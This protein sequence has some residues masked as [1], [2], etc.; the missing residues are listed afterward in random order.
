MESKLTDLPDLT[1]SGDY[2]L[3]SFLLTLN[4]DLDDDDLEKLK[5]LCTG[6]Y[7]I[8]E[9]ILENVKKP[10]HL[11]EILRKRQLLNTCNLITLQAMLWVLPRKDL[12]L[13]YVKFADSQKSS[14]HFIVPKDSPE[15]GY[16]FLKFHIKGADLNKYGTGDMEKLRSKISKLLF[17]PPE[18]V[19]IAGIQPSQSLLI[20]VMLLKDDAQRMLTLPP[21]SIAVLTEVHVDKVMIGNKTLLLSGEA[22][23]VTVPNPAS[24]RME[25]ELENVLLRHKQ[26]E[27]E[28][29]NAYIT[30]FKLQSLLASNSWLL[31]YI[32]V[33]LLQDCR[34]IYSKIC[35]QKKLLEN[36]FFN[37]VDELHKTSVFAAFR[38]RLQKA[39]EHGYNEVI[40]YDL[41][42][43]QALVFQW[44]RNERICV[45][46]E[47]LKIEL[48]Y[49]AWE[50]EKLA[51]YHQVGVQD[52]IMSQR[53]EFFISAM[54]QNLPI[55]VLQNVEIHTQLSDE[56]VEYVFHR[57]SQDVSE[58]ELATLKKI[59]K[60]QGKINSPAAASAYE[61]LMNSW[62]EQNGVELHVF[63]QEVLV[64]PLKRLDFLK[65]LDKYVIEFHDSKTKPDHAS[66]S[67]DE[68]KSGSPSSKESRQY[69]MQE[70]II[71]RLSNIE[72]C[73]KR[74]ELNPQNRLHMGSFLD[75]V[76]LNP[77]GVINPAFPYSKRLVE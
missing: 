24:S 68:M 35:A 41:L 54:I 63:V 76:G 42:D 31:H 36:M 7:G 52:K 46:I 30:I 32:M 12:Q 14:I 77:S 72:A 33:V 75:N 74:L 71:K 57:L 38:H 2:A 53:D 17:V 61:Y 51:Y 13:K 59:S 4:D 21:S 19:I 23:S 39:K 69:D 18:F 8:G 27:T 34:D 67:S 11:F 20:T 29:E 1:P 70:E 58:C 62:K 28:L 40:I 22:N 50:K 3:N 55:P 56:C 25:E 26:K 16:E 15:N 47:R 64:I 48:A 73:V 44:H 66:N 6:K 45:E 9:A 10:I 60:E 49:L 65:Q 43:A 5:F 37:P